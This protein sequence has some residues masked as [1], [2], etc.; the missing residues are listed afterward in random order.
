MILLLNG[1]ARAHSETA[2]HV[3]D[4]WPAG[5]AEPASVDVMLST[6]DGRNYISITMPDG[7][8]VKAE[9]VLLEDKRMKFQLTAIR[10]ERLV[11]IQY[12]GSENAAGE[13]E[14]RFSAMV[15]GEA[16]RDMSGRFTLR[17]KD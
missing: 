14:G 4:L 1:P 7:D 13:I 15:D 6:E 16:R 11:S 2:T 5:A 12:V 9:Y 3:M 8:L 10:D 17:K